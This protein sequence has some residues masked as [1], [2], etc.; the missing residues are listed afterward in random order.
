M[1]ILVCF[2]N[3]TMN[4]K[5]FIITGSQGSGKTTLLKSIINGIKSNDIR[6]GG[7]LAEGYWNENIRDKFEL[8]NL[9]SGDRMIYCQRQPESGWEQIRHFY[10]NPHAVIFGEKAMDTLTLSD[11]D[12]IVVD[13][14]GPFEL[15]GKGW[16]KSFSKILQE[17]DLPVVISVRQSLLEEVIE[18]WKLNVK[19]VFDVHESTNKQAL[20]N[21]LKEIE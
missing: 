21:I 2:L 13:E 3:T 1:E 7:L 9:K 12:L 11:V 15:A 17:T 18:H 19:E 6:I 4:N 8:I 10:I 16:A 20:E 5:I 14:I